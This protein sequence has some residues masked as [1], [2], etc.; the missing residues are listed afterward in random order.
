MF[1]DIEEN[2]ESDLKTLESATM[3]NTPWFTIKDFTTTAKVVKV[4][5]GDTCTCVF[6][7]YELGFYKHSVRLAGIDT[8]EIQGKS[9]E[10]KEEACKVRDFVRGKILGHIVKLECKGSDKYGRI[11]GIITGPS[12][13]VI[14]DLLVSKGMALKYDGGK[15]AEFSFK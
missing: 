2:S 7:T 3:K 5:D 8:P 6:N 15:K 10:E 4:Y 11:L 14:N 13:E 1:K 12:G 9:F